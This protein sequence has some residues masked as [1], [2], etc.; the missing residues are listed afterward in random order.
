MTANSESFYVVTLA[1]CRY[2]CCCCCCSTYASS[3]VTRC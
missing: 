2:M 1:R 3:A